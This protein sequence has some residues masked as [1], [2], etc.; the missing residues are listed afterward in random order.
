L[1]NSNSGTDTITFDAAAFATPQT[2]TLTSGEL[3]ITDSVT[4]NGPGANLLTISGNSSSRVFFIA[5]GPYDVTLSGLT[6]ANGRYTAPIGAGGGIINFS[7]GTVTLTNSTLSGNS[8]NGVGVFP[9][10]GGGIFNS[11]TL[12]ITNSTLSGNSANGVDGSGPG[13]GIYNTGTVTL[14]NSTLSGNSA[15][16]GAGALGRGCLYLN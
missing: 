6:V 16:G 5:T 3:L 8:V 12:N 7:I 1:A 15:N 2:I 4:V 9:G 13:G 10:A 14:T 11:G